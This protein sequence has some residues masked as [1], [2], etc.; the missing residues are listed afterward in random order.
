MFGLGT[1]KAEL[2]RHRLFELRG[3]QILLTPPHQHRA[4]SR[5]IGVYGGHG[6]DRR[7]VISVAGHGC[8]HTGKHNKNGS[9]QDFTVAQRAEAMGIDWMTGSELSQAIPPAYTEFI[10][11]ALLERIQS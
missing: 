5:V 1:G 7:R 6:I 10:G 3:F 2:W 8:G 4:A 9:V 11:R